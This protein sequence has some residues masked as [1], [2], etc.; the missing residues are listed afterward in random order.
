MLWR[1]RLQHQKAWKPTYPPAEG[2]STGASAPAC[3]EERASDQL[4]ARGDAR[5]RGKLL[6]NAR[7]T[8]ISVKAN[9]TLTTLVLTVRC[10][11]LCASGERGPRH[12]RARISGQQGGAEKGQLTLFHPVSQVAVSLFYILDVH[13]GW[14]RQPLASCHTGGKDEALL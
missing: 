11:C 8:S 1:P 13:N 14:C 9:D 5:G 7:I 2:T 12:T 3:P 4:L 10:A 6:G